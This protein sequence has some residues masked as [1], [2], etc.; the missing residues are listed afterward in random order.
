M[1]GLRGGLRARDQPPT[2]EV[3]PSGHRTND[4]PYVIRSTSSGTQSS[5]TGC[6]ARAGV[7]GFEPDRLRW[8]RQVIC[9]FRDVLRRVV[10]MRLYRA[11]GWI[12]RT[13]PIRP[14]V[15]AL[16]VGLARRT[17]AGMIGPNSHG[18]VLRHNGRP[19]CVMLN[20]QRHVADGRNG[21]HEAFVTSLC[22]HV[23]RGRLDQI[24]SRNPNG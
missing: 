12:R 9:L 8:R 15:Q 3:R 6:G 24:S 10:G 18:R 5:N 19:V 1:V 14:V 11:R 16:V 2:E 7:R 23:Y 4:D 17:V 20:N 21:L 13:R 22:W